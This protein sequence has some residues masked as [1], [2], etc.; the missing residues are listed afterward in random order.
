VTLSEAL[1]G[2]VRL[3]NLVDGRTVVYTTK[4]GEIVSPGAIRKLP[5]C[6]MPLG[7]GGGERG[8]QS[9]DLYL[10]FEVEFP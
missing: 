3:I 2:F 5:G 1:T 10:R 9:G 8:G 6:G 4:E 7:G